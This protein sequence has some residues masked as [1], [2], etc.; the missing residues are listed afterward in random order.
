VIS[1]AFKR[2]LQNRVFD[3]ANRVTTSFTSVGNEAD[4]VMAADV[5][6]IT[7]RLTDPAVKTGPGGPHTQC[8]PEG[9]LLCTVRPWVL[10][11]LLCSQV[12]QMARAA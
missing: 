11:T 6:P 1:S 12:G 7:S 3:L 8:L 5:R 10:V 4:R 9:P 2:R